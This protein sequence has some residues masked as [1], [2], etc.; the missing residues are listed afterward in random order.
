M[1]EFKRTNV[2][3]SQILFYIF[4]TKI[5]IVWETFC[6]WRSLESKP[7]VFHLFSRWYLS[8]D[9]LI[10]YLEQLRLPRLEI[11]MSLKEGKL[12][13]REHLWKRICTLDRAQAFASQGP[14]SSEDIDIVSVVRDLFHIIY[15][16]SK[17][18]IGRNLWINLFQSYFDKCLI[19]QFEQYGS[20]S[21]YIAFS[22]VLNLIFV[23]FYDLG[24]DVTRCSS[25][26]VF[27]RKVIFFYRW[28]KSYYS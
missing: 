12:G 17:F 18:L 25:D 22:I 20:C 11:K 13:Y 6:L 14:D 21:E 26:L 1:N 4:L 19:L 7:T 27:D 24:S 10:K 9:Q 8:R 16:I 3:T 5:I 15:S 23:I 28:T 2:K